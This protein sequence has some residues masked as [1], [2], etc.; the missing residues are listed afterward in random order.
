MSGGVLTT[1][2]SLY[3]QGRPECYEDFY[4]QTGIYILLAG[5]V[6]DVVAFLNCCTSLCPQV[7]AA[8]LQYDSDF[9][10][11]SDEEQPRPTIYR[12]ISI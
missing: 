1:L 8:Q 3:L 12:S 9:T 4:N 5:L 10:S 7:T 2:G 6:L 11:D